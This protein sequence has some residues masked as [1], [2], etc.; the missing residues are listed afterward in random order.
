MSLLLP[1][2]PL[3]AEEE[4]ATRELLRDGLYAEEVSRDTE[5]A[6]EH[7]QKVL[8][9]HDQQQPFAATALF[10]LAEVRRKQDRKEEAI[11]FYQRLIREFPAAEPELKLARENL[12]A[13]G[14]AMPE[15][16]SDGT[17]PKSDDVENLER[18]K[19]LAK[20]SPDRLGEAQ[21]FQE[22]IMGNRMESLAFLLN[23]A[24]PP[25]NESLLPFATERGSLESVKLL[26]QLGVDPNA[27]GENLALPRAAALGHIHIAKAL[28]AGGADINWSPDQC[29]VP[30]PSA[31][32]SLMVIGTPLMEAIATTQEKMV[33]L[34]LQAKA[35]VKEPAGGTGYTALHI[36]AS[37]NDTG[38]VR[39]LLDA[40]ADPD[41]VAVKKVDDLNSWGIDGTVSPLDYALQL[42]SEKAAD[43]IAKAGG[44]IRD[45]D[46]L[47][48]AVLSGGPGEVRKL[49][50]LGADP[51]G[52]YKNKPLLFEADQEKA[53][54]L[55]AAGADPN[56]Q[57]GEFSILVRA[58]ASRKWDLANH[59][60]DK[61]ADPN[62]QIRDG[63]LLP[64]VGTLYEEG[65]LSTLQRLI[66]KGVKPDP[67]WVKARFSSGFYRMNGPG[68]RVQFRP[69]LF[70]H[71]ILPEL[72]DREE[73]RWVGHDSSITRI[74][75]LCAK[76][77]EAEPP[78]LAQAL[79][80]KNEVEWSIP[81]SSS[82]P[83]RLI[84]WRK[85]ADAKRVPIEFSSDDPEFPALKWGDIVEATVRPDEAGPGGVEARTLSGPAAWMLRQK[86]AFDVSFEIGGK[87]RPV[88]VNGSRLVF[89][90][91]RNE[92]PYVGARGLAILM[93]GTVWA[94]RG[95]DDVIAIR[96]EGLPEITIPLWESGE[97]PLQAGDEVIFKD[98][99]EAENPGR[100]SEIRIVSPGI[101]YTTVIHLESDV[102]AQQERPPLAMPT[103]FQT[104][105]EL[106][107]RNQSIMQ[108]A[109]SEA[110]ALGPWMCS[111]GMT[112][113]LAPMILPH[114]DLS[115]IT[116]RRL[117]Q[118]GG[119]EAI[120]VDLSA[121]LEAADGGLTPEAARGHDRILQAG[122]IVEIPVLEGHAGKPWQGLGEKER[123]L[124]SKALDCQV[125]YTSPS[126]KVEVKSFFYRTPRYIAAGAQAV[127]IPPEFGTSSF[128]IGAALQLSGN[129]K[130]SRDG[131]PPTEESSYGTYLRDGLRI[132]YDNQH[133]PIIR[134]PAPAE[135][136]VSPPA[137]R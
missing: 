135:K 75:T 116:I 73:V 57:D 24:G 66:E 40:G 113:Q 64:L 81:P 102:P 96:R 3:S 9:L 125:Q 129:V 10:R 83:I 82:R 14:A 35:D 55:L 105:A 43:L 39:R 128:N 48:K 44:K 106:D 78:P 115:K 120:R 46:L 52:T 34:L 22:A 89:D 15:D 56:M 63:K 131:F 33:D 76:T 50:E 80:E 23:T 70:R 108:R 99:P 12:T 72:E 114:P 88:R 111:K 45:P 32:H 41:A 17:K 77:S 4:A 67:A 31:T 29:S 104:I 97:F 85:E 54:I 47:G 79:L 92:V 60:L 68:I 95:E 126:N 86:I 100:R 11:K 20:S 130:I 36:A 2:S 118:D 51:N 122:D 123:L 53:L 74:E 58:I 136:P 42:G 25:E 127:P 98:G 65:G 69:I 109:P 18:L 13:M 59:L 133:G 19:N 6:A 101:P 49:L 91:T 134:P 124:L 107:G 5:K 121:A 137:A 117:K 21:L 7:Y 71:F 103:L 8:D 26:L 119:E 90:P 84:I 93:S 30:I 38:M 27:E 94:N 112:G 61:G 87:S 132:E 1:L 37:K 110:E 28:L 62:P 16:Q